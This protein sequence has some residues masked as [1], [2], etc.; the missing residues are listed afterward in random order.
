MSRAAANAGVDAFA[1]VAAAAAEV[2]II[3]CIEPLSPDQT[4]CINTV[5][6]AVGIVNHQ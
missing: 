2:G 1:A 4:S 3:Y 5:S 6:E